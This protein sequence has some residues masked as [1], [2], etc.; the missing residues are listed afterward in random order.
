M[1]RQQCSTRKAWKKYCRRPRTHIA[2]IFT[3][4]GLVQYEKIGCQACV[5]AWAAGHAATAYE[6]RILPIADAAPLVS[7]RLANGTQ[8]FIPS[9]TWSKVTT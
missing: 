9:P 4:N 7:T 2:R 1:K 6:T 5:E 8:G 3:P